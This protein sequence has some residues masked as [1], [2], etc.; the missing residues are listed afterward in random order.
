M[1]KIITFCLLFCLTISLAQSKLKKADKLFKE[2]KY[3]EAAQTYEEYLEKESN[4]S[5]EAVTHIADTYY[6]LDK[7]REALTWYRKLYELQGQTLSDQYLI[8]YT[9]SLR[10]VRDYDKADEITKNELLKK[11]DD[12]QASH[13]MAQKK[14]NDSLASRPSL[15]TIKPVAINSSK[16]DFGPAFYGNQLVYSSAKD[17][18]KFHEKL[19]SWNQQPFLEL[20]VADRNISTGELFNELPFLENIRSKYHDATVT[21]TPDLK[22]IYYTTNTLK[23]SRLLNDKEGV[24]NFQILRATITDGKASEPEKMFFNSL[25]FSVGHPALSPDGKWLFFVSDMPGGYGETDIY[26]AEVFS[27]GKLNSPLNLGP[28]INT[29][30]REMFPFYINN[31]LYFSSDGH[32]GYGGLDV[33]ESKQSG[34]LFFSEPK[35]LGEPINSNKDDFSF[36]IDPELKFGYF[37]SNRDT[38]KGDDDIY[39]F[40]K[41]KAP[42]D[43]IVSGKVINA[44]SKLS[45]D[46]AIVKVF[47]SFGDYKTEVTTLPNGEYQ[48]TIPCG[49]S[50]RLQASK[51]KFVPQEKEVITGLKNQ[52]QIKDVNFELANLDDFVVIEDNKKKVD[53]NPIFFEYDKWG[54]TPQAVIELDKVVYVMNTFPKVKIKIESHTDSRG[55]DLYNMMLSDKRA[56]ATQEYILSKGIDPGRI[57]SAIGYGE[58]RL[59]NRCSNGVKCSDEEHLLNR[60][61]D[62]I[63]IEE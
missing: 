52:D 25:D 12:K 33:F 15:F 9:Q 56:K 4:P 49:G 8:R 38:G 19:Y 13:F 36:I 23:K 39:Y 59:R 16:S 54:I 31:T 41:A 1:K 37:S 14:Y 20:Y 55:K 34:K 40:T 47:D 60:R 46:G 18:T 26:V 6:F 35:N 29:A 62:F 30:G 42:C 22:T 17:T 61:S 58:K 48:V 51:T 11:R 63:I 7:P 5:I 43:Q 2:L 10:G 50:Y 45:L 3:V 27:D 44:K 21:F 53:I 28:T 32:Y 24:N 57:E